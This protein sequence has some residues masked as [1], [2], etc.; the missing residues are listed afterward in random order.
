MLFVPSDSRTIGPHPDRQA[1]HREIADALG[2]HPSH[3]RVPTVVIA[4]SHLFD[5]VWRAVAN[6]QWSTRLRDGYVALHRE[7]E[8]E[9][10]AKT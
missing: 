1:V 10:V 5:E 3:V 9:F 6:N 8:I 7:G 4:P 2:V